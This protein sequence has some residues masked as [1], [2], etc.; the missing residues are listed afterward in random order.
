MVEN[1][2]G[3]IV[4]ERGAGIGLCAGGPGVIRAPVTAVATHA[5]GD[6]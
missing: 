3:R 5:T 6:P 1:E 4:D 2:L